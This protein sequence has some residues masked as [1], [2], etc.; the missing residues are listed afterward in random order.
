MWYLEE[1]RGPIVLLFKT[2]AEVL[3]AYAKCTPDFDGVI[4]WVI[5]FSPN[6]ELP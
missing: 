3:A 2:H 6:G 5:K 4:P 1:T